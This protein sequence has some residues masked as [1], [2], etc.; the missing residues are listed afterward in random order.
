LRG[1]H[2]VLI[3]ARRKFCISFCQ[4]AGFGLMSIALMVFALTA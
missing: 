3:M 2:V 4:I 1:I